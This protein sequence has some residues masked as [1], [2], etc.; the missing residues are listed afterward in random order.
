MRQAFPLSLLI[1]GLSGIP[2]LSQEYYGIVTAVPVY[3]TIVVDGDVSDW[4]GIAPACLDPSGD[5]GL[6][7]D[8]A[9]CYLA[10]DRDYFYF[11]ITFTSPQPYG[12]YFW[13]LNT[14]FDTDM[15]SNTGHRWP[16]VFGSEF[17]I[18]GRQV[19]DQRCG[20][21]VCT[22]DPASEENLWGTFAYVDVAPMEG[23]VTD[24]EFAIRRDLVYKNMEDGQPGLS[25]PDESPLFDPEFNDFILVFETEDETFTSVEWMPD[26]DPNSNETGIIYTFAPPPADVPG[27]DL[28]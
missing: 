22:I 12:D 11:R 23:N 17:N 19:F 16:A 27:W 2:S 6:H 25:N 5:G 8:F 9:A 24:V 14:G 13:Y 15:D 7:Y 10:N 21:W 1:L 18:Q 28:Y 20:D 26:T 3:R 4:D